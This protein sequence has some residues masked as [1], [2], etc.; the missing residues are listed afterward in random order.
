MNT[1]GDCPV[2]G[3][4]L[5]LWDG[6]KAPAPL[7]LACPQCNEKLVVEL[8]MRWL[9]VTLVV[10][11][12]IWLGVEAVLQLCY[13]QFTGFFWWIAMMAALLALVALIGSIVYFNFADLMVPDD[14]RE[15]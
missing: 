2:C 9:F 3:A 7:S 1:Q 4:T 12:Y 8:P 11:A 13:L 15:F 6:F 5:T 14:S 10:L